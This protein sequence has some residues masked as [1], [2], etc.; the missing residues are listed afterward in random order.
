MSRE[1]LHQTPNHSETALWRDVT[2]FRDQKT[3]RYKLSHAAVEAWRSSCS[4]LQVG[5]WREP[6]TLLGNEGKHN[7]SKQ[8]SF[9]CVTTPR[10]HTNLR[11]WMRTLIVLLLSGWTPS[12]YHSPW[13]TWK[14]RISYCIRR[15]AEQSELRN[16]YAESH[17]LFDLFSVFNRT[18]LPQ[19]SAYNSPID[20]MPD[21]CSSASSNNVNDFQSYS[22]HFPIQFASHGDARFCTE[23]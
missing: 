17:L 5:G 16:P 11:F 13:I 2:C 9:H 12:Y 3:L 6:A 8:T 23:T 19:R 18:S 22:S 10:Y 4:F 7:R 15:G 1:K 14:E 21:S 20:N